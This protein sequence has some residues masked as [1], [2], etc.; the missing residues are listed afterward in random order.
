[1]IKVLT[2][3]LFPYLIPG[4][5]QI[6]EGVIRY[7][8]AFSLLTALDLSGTSVKVGYLGMHSNVVNFK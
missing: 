6:T 3:M 7:I 5:P 4:N 2:Y 1:M 8:L